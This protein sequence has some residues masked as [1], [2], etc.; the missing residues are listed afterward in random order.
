M[1]IKPTSN[2]HRNLAVYDAI[3]EGAIHPGDMRRR[4]LQWIAWMAE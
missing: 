3:D 2:C 4:S 1:D